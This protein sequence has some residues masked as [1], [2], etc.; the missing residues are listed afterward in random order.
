VGAAIEAEAVGPLQLRGFTQ[1]VAA[2]K[3]KAVKQ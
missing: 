3:V 1:P 2:F